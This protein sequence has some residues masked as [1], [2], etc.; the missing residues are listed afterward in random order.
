V[1]G[2]TK[3]D[4]HLIRPAPSPSVKPREGGG[5]KKM[6]ACEGPRCLAASKHEPLSLIRCPPP[7]SLGGG[8]G[9]EAKGGP[10]GPRRGMTSSSRPTRWPVVSPSVAAA[11][12]RGPGS[13]PVGAEGTGTPPPPHPS[14]SE[15]PLAQRQDG[16][17]QSRGETFTHKAIR[18]RVA[19][20]LVGKLGKGDQIVRRSRLGRHPRTPAGPRWA[21][22]GGPPCGAGG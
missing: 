3:R 18:G 17:G 6:G 16:C 21:G 20:T 12:T 22:T 5:G 11:A 13:R 9:G 2:Q 10:P 14:P 15:P 8:G 1:G 4:E 7:P 19:T